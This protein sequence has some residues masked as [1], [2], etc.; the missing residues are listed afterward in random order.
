MQSDKLCLVLLCL[1]YRSADG[2]LNGNDVAN[3]EAFSSDF[4]SWKYTCCDLAS[5]AVAFDRWHSSIVA[6]LTSS[7]TNLQHCAASGLA[8]PSSLMPANMRDMHY[9]GV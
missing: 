6:L 3:C 1:K 2:F 8:H 9:W 4:F 7:R 5:S